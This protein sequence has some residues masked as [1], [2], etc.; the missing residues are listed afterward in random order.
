MS[1]VPTW[2]ELENSISVF[3]EF[4]TSMQL[5]VDDNCL[6]NEI[7]CLNNYITEKIWPNG[8]I[9]QLAMVISGWKFLQL[10]VLRIFCCPIWNC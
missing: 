3:A 1:V 7:T 6:F 5:T 9:K 8:E 2:V 4:V 10:Y